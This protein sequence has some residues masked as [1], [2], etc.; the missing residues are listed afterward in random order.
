MTEETE[1]STYRHLRDKRASW[2]AMAQSY[3]FLCF[4]S[5]SRQGARRANSPNIR[6]VKKV[7][8]VELW[9]VRVA[10]EYVPGHCRT[11]ARQTTTRMGDEGD[12]TLASGSSTGKVKRRDEQSAAAASSLWLSRFPALASPSSAAFLVSTSMSAAA[13]LRICSG[14]GTNATAFSSRRSCCRS[15]VCCF[16]RSVVAETTRWTGPLTDRDRGDG[17]VAGAYF[18]RGRGRR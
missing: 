5:Q 6:V 14:R 13:A 15:F 11:A 2:R 16:P 4:F 18:L 10:P 1:V 8:G 3:D 9:S 7:K 12:S 17:L